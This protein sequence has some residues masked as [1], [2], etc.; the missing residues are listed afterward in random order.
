MQADPP[1]VVV[2]A[3][4][5]G[6]GKIVSREAGDAVVIKAREL[7]P[8]WVA[9]HLIEPALKRGWKLEPI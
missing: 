8:D 3:G 9:S 4:P 7:L 5:N 2:V 6:S 1:F